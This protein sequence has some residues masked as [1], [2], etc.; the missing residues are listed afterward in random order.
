MGYRYIFMLLLASLTMAIIYVVVD[1]GIE[2][3][4]FSLSMMYPIIVTF[5]MFL[6]LYCVLLLPITILLRK[7][8]SQ[9]RFDL[10]HLILYI[11]AATII[12]V[13]AYLILRIESTS[14]MNVEFYL[15]VLIAAIVY[16][17]YETVL[18]PDNTES[19]S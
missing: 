4:G 11:A 15:Y 7:W 16:W 1:F 2:S 10:I 8:E 5:P 12:T 13:P 9:D 14:W 19:A 3:K 17:I 6:A 18:L